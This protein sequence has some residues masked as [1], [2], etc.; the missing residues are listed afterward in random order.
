[1]TDSSQEIT[2]ANY[3]L[4]P[5][6]VVLPS[7][8]TVV[9]TVLGSSVSVCLYDRK[10]KKGA[11][12]CFQFP[13]IREKGKTTTR[14]GNV[15]ILTLIRMMHEDGSKI[16]NLE[17]Q[18]IGGAYN[19]AVS[20][21]NIGQENVKIARNILTREKILI[22]SEDVGGSKGRKIVFS[23]HSNEIAVFKVERLRKMDWFPYEDDRVP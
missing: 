5:G 9:S 22:T 12:N 21:L 7:I 4:Y 10:R 8:P 23:A 15:A 18:I 13:F 6:F 19:P 3:F 20:K 2:S 17:A 14:Y 1:M 16:K 11:M